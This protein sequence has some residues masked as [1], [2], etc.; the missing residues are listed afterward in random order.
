MFQPV[1]RS[2]PV[3]MT[4]AGDSESSK[5]KTPLTIGNGRSAP[6]SAHPSHTVA[7]Q[8]KLPPSRDSKRPSHGLCGHDGP[9]TWSL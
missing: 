9:V 5:N 7:T 3:Y 8:L 4:V 2:G 6:E 1:G